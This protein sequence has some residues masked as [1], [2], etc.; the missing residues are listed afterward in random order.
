MIKIKK[1]ELEQLEKISTGGNGAIYRVGNY[2]YKIY[3]PYTKTSYKEEI[4]NPSLKYRPLKLHRLM[5]IDKKIKYTD[6]VQEIIF[7][8]GKFGGVVLPFYNGQILSETMNLPIEEKIKISREVVR[9][10]SELTYHHIYPMDYK[11][12]NIMLS[13]G[14]PKIIDLDDWTTKVK[15]RLHPLRKAL[16]IEGL[17]ET[18]KTYLSEYRGIPLSGEVKEKIRKIP[19][20]P[21]Y[22]YNGI[23]EYLDEKSQIHNYI[24]IFE[25]SD[26]KSNLRLLH[27]D[28]YRIILS[29]K[30][31][32]FDDSHIKKYLEKLNY[33]GIDIY[34]ITTLNRIDDY[35]N[36]S[37][38]KEYI[39]ITDKEVKIKKIDR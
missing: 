11:L 24:F 34:D 18:I 29:F 8:D 28:K 1:S 23:L 9:N 16:C 12:N 2:I 39:K 36:N 15:F 5:S 38:Y 21:N 3:K 37:V 20:Q 10:S 6:L 25:S 13:D 30:D 7:V 14:H 4:P 33:Y 35:I 22:S 26:I 27:D 17:D 19:N 32:Y 31:F